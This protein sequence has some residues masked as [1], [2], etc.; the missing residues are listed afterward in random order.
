LAL[1]FVLPG[2]ASL[3]G[4]GTDAKVEVA[5]WTFVRAPDGLHLVGEI[6]NRGPTNADALRIVARFADARGD[7]I[8]VGEAPAWRHLLE[9]GESSPFDLA[10]P[11]GAASANVTA[12][13]ESTR[14]GAWERQ[15]LYAQDPEVKADASAMNA[16]FR[17]LAVNGGE[18]TVV[19]VEAQLTFR[20]PEGRV[21]GVARAPPAD[22]AI[23]AGQSSAF[24]GNATMA[25]PFDHYD[26]TIVTLAPPS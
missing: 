20:A 21:V 2:C 8:S 10:A 16:T 4:P 5:S 25:A 24:A 13:G 6:A 26:I 23:R 17:G 3:R 11:E 12:L 18:L 22:A 9:P 7:P 14:Q 19:S 15:R 1:A